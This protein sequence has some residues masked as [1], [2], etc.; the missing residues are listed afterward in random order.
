MVFH[1]YTDGEASFSPGFGRR[2]EWEW[3]KRQKGLG[4]MVGESLTTMVVGWLRFHFLKWN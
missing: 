4:V 3:W 2:W 1:D